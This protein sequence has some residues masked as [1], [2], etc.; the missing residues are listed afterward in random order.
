MKNQQNFNNLFWVEKT[1][2]EIWAVVPGK[3]KLENQSKFLL[4]LRFDGNEN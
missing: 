2:E 1:K 4:F 3:G